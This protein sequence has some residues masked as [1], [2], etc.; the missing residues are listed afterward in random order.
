[1]S[2]SICG[3]SKCKCGEGIEADNNAMEK[4]KLLKYNEWL[5]KEYLDDFEEEVYVQNDK[6]DSINKPIHYNAGN[7]QTIEH[8]LDIIIDGESYCIGNVIKY[9]SR[10]K[11]KGGIEDLKKAIWYINKT[12]EILEG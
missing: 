9:V 6:M 10:Y 5:Q 11:Y 1:M 12:I 2:C 7:I 4:K 3:L 8:I